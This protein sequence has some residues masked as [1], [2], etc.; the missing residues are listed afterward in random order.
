MSPKYERM[1]LWLT[2]KASNDSEYIASLR[3]SIE[4]S[5]IILPGQCKIK[6]NENEM[7]W[8]NMIPH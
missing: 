8:D 2:V 4:D 7:A 6:E 3:V 5:S 1:T